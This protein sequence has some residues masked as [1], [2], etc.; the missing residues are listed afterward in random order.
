MNGP[1]RT[2]ARNP[3]ATHATASLL[4]LGGL[5][6][7]GL[8][9]KAYSHGAGTYTGIEAVSNG[10]GSLREP[11]VWLKAGDEVVISSPQLGV[12]ETRLA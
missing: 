12:L 11:K 10:V 4:P 6:S 8:L 5:A 1:G 9:L 3:A 7:V 2:R